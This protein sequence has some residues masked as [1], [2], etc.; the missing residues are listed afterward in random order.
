M[1]VY[2]WFMLANAGLINVGSLKFIMAKLG[3]PYKK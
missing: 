1:L 2:A 3:L